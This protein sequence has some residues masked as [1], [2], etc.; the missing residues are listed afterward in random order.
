[1]SNLLL[2]G[3][4]VVG[5]ED[6]RK[7]DVLVHGD[8]IEQVAEEINSTPESRVIDCSGKLVLPGAIDP[9]T[10][11]GIPIK[12]GWSADDFAS[13]S[14]AALFGGVTTILDFTVLELGQTLH[15]SV[16][17]RRELAKDSLCDFSLHCN[18]TRFSES[19]LEE[20]PDLVKQGVTSFKVFTAYGE[21]GMRLSYEQIERVAEVVRDSGGMLMV[22]AEDDDLV[23]EATSRIQ[24]RTSTDPRMHGIAR[25]A[26]AEALSVDR[27][28]A[29]AEKTGCSIYIVHL[30]SEAGLERAISHPSLILETCPQY[31]LLD[32]SVYA[33]PDGR[34]YVA[35]PPVRKPQDNAALWSAVA[36]GRIE[37]LG[38]DHCPFRIEDKPEATPFEKIP[39][40]M[41]G[42]E[43]LLPL[44]LAQFI[45]RKLDLTKLAGL[46]STNAAKRFG[47]YPRKGI[48]AVGADADL[49][50][51]DPG[52]KSAVRAS[53]LHSVADWSAYE[54]RSAVFPEMVVRGG[55]IAVEKGNLFVSQP[56]RFL[57]AM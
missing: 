4:T 13:G 17:K 41:G 21:A 50:I 52:Q 57:P 5:S 22:H 26:A 25:P 45:E 54:G 20:I 10:H 7:A 18:I 6:I 49:V 31:L 15:E 24:D 30:S 55:E 19:L 33:K 11:M 16:A 40:G 27:L 51:V 23:I 43:T 14:R 36:G 53:T 42:I 8:R 46:L 44:M 3:G 38:T 48:V 28:G 47:L 1:M 56:G 37:T 35:S 12:D 34:M 32:D 2:K 29:I 39:N 9:H